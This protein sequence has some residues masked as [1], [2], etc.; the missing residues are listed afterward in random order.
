MI[1]R[2]KGQAFLM[3]R[4]HDHAIISEQVIA[5]LKADFFPLHPLNDSVLYAIKM[6]DF[7]WIRFDE[8]PFWN[9]LKQEPYSFIDFPNTVK[10]V[11]YKHGIDEVA[12]EDLYAGLL[13]SKHY[14]YFLGKD[15]SPE[16]YAFV[17]DEKDRQKEIIETLD[18]DEELLQFHFELL[19]FAD[20]FSLFLCLHE[21]G[22]KKDDVHYFFEKGIYLPKTFHEYVGERLHLDWQDTETIVSSSAIFTDAFKLSIP[23]TEV[24]KNTVKEQG[25]IKS[26]QEADEKFVEIYIN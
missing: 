7:G 5:R 25:L 8:A 11:L 10:T 13:V 22:Y 12:K 14:T 23:Y 9:D 15:S 18:V 1:I 21:P 2:E 16:V 4:Q 26:F 3:Y 19:K 6:H 20:D 24:F 17:A